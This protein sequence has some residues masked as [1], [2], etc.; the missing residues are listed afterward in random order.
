MS[1][2]YLFTKR[3]YSSISRNIKENLLP[4]AFIFLSGSKSLCKFAFTTGSIKVIQ[5][6]AKI[7]AT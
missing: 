7:K 4:E 3:D 5:Q 6:L 1:V 2:F